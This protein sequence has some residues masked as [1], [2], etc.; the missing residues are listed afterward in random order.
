MLTEAMKQDDEANKLPLSLDNMK[1]K[2]TLSRVPQLALKARLLIER[3]LPIYPIDDFMSLRMTSTQQ[4]IIT[5]RVKVFKSLSDNHFC[6]VT[7]TLHEAM[8]CW[9]WQLYFPSTQR[10]FICTFY[11]SDLFN[12][13]QENFQSIDFTKIQTKKQSIKQQK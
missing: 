4:R 9:I 2:Q 5:N 11:S 1:D 3:V 12:I 13:S 8:E 6:L 7:V 10:T